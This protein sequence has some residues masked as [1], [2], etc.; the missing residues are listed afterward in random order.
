MCLS[1]KVVWNSRYDFK[2]LM[3]DEGERKSK[4]A[5]DDYDIA[6]TDLEEYHRNQI[7]QHVILNWSLKD[8]PNKAFKLCS[9]SEY[10]RKLPGQFHICGNQKNF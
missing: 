6:W 7:E 1:F 8:L 10:K 2:L 3:N 5:M 9:A 4:N